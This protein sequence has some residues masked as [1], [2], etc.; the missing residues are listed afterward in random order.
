MDVR[1]VQLTVNDCCKYDR[2]KESAKAGCYF[3]DICRYKLV[4]A[5]KFLKQEIQ[6]ERLGMF[7]LF[8]SFMQQVM[9][10]K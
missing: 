5:M 7:S 4:R 10:T 9:Y 6:Q 8:S 1:R 2:E 3:C